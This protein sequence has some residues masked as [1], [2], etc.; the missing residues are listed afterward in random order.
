MVVPSIQFL[1][2]HTLPCV[3]STVVGR[4]EHVEQEGFCIGIVSQ[5]PERISFTCVDGGCG[6]A[7]GFIIIE[8]VTH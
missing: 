2:A 8:D 1:V 5:E 4:D 7:D 6:K 3:F